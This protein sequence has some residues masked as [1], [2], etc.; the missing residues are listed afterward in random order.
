MEHEST[1]PRNTGTLLARMDPSVEERDRKILEEVAA[2]EVSFEDLGWLA[3]LNEM[4]EQM[5]SMESVPDSFIESTGC[6]QLFVDGLERA[7]TALLKHVLAI[8]DTVVFRSDLAFE[9]FMELDPARRYFI[10]MFLD[11]NVPWNAK[12]QIT[13]IVSKMIDYKNMSSYLVES[14]TMQAILGVIQNPHVDI[15]AVQNVLLLTDTFIRHSNESEIRSVLEVIIT[16]VHMLWSANKQN[17]AEFILPVLSDL[18]KHGF[19][20]IVV[21]LFDVREFAALLENRD[22]I[23]SYG[24]IARLLAVMIKHNPEWIQFIHCDWILDLMEGR[25]RWQL[26]DYFELLKA[27]AKAGRISVVLEKDGDKVLFDMITGTER[28]YRSRE[29]A[30]LLLWHGFV[31]LKTVAEQSG[32]MESSYYPLM[33]SGIPS[34]SLA[35]RVLPILA[36]IHDMGIL[37]PEAVQ[38]TRELL[39][40]IITESSDTDVVD[41]AEA[42]LRLYL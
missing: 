29:L 16:G 4:N 42:V 5:K 40:A 18:C 20:E 24:G 28:E 35:A 22:F 12:V 2:Q 30:L 7:N 31:G 6:V 8:I 39:G 38:N 33:I 15:R 36:S 14:N 26:E 13:I 9:Q 11:S 19:V 27:I 10:P 34:E 23:A 1:Q 21:E 3:K 37:S 32:M 25:G 41:K 17:L